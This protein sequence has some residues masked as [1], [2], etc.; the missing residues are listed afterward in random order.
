MR[1]RVLSFLTPVEAF[2][3]LRSCR[4]LRAEV[5]AAA[6]AHI[7]NKRRGASV[8]QL[9]RYLRERRRTGDRIR[10]FARERTDA[11]YVSVIGVRLINGW[12]LDYLDGRP[13]ETCLDSDEEDNLADMYGMYYKLRI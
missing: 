11:P 6:R 9:G 13:F 5:E 2:A 3:T 1:E 10:L 7:L 4:A 8:D 12:R